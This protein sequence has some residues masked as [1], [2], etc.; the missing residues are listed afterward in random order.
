MYYSF[1]MNIM[2]EISAIRSC[3]DILANDCK[4]DTTNQLLYS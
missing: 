3:I 1:R 2:E 4:V